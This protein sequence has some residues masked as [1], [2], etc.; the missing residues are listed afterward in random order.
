MAARKQQRWG[1]D[2][3]HAVSSHL[4]KL[5]IAIVFVIAAG[6]WTVG[7]L[8]ER[9]ATRRDRREVARITKEMET[10]CLG[11]FL[12][13]MP[14]EAQIRLLKLHVDG[15]NIESFQESAE[16]FFT[17]LALREKRLKAEPK[18]LEDINYLE[19][20]AEVKTANGV[21]GKIFVHGR[22]LTEGTQMNGLQLE[23]YRYERIEVEG[24]VHGDGISFEIGAKEYDPDSAED[25]R[26]LIT[27]LVPNRANRGPD[28]SGFCFDRGWFRDPLSA[29]Q[30][31]QTTIVAQL[32]SHP[33]VHFSISVEAGMKPDEQGFLERSADSYRKFSRAELKRIHKLRAAERM[34]AG[35]TGDELVE[36]FDEHNNIVVHSFWWE[37]MGTENDVYAPRISFEMDTGKANNGQVSSSLSRSGALALWDKIS[38]SIRLHHAPPA[39]GTRPATSADPG[40]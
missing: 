7:Q 4:A 17:R 22:T 9:E 1:L 37:H 32:R 35:L 26:K 25:L 6:I 34:L 8:R 15:F 2:V 5:G 14:R 18:Q 23:R 24:M 11:R 29:D 39:P 38:S 36:E 33:D 3:K 31:E 27:K 13:D 19:S 40:N 20:I 30:G 28:G 12:I 16:D 21:V 10:V